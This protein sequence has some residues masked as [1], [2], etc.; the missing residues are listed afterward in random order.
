VT[1]NAR[2]VL[3]TVAQPAMENTPLDIDLRTF[4]T[5]DLTAANL[6]S[7]DPQRVRNGTATMLPNG[8]TARFTPAPNFNGTASFRITARDRSLGPRMLFLYDFE[9]PDVATDAR[10]T[11]QSNFNRTGTLEI[12]GVGGEYNYNANVPPATIPGSQSLGL[13][14]NTT[15]GA[16]LRRTLA[17][18]DQNYNDADW[19]FSAWVKRSTRDT[20]DYIF[21]LGNGD[22]GGGNAELQLFFPATS[23]ILRLQKYSTSAL[24]NEI[25]GP[26]PPHRRVAPRHRGL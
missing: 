2:P 15:G 8:Y 24:T 10:S 26:K 1:V 20:D 5:D 7:F 25:V 11:D 14:E 12:A 4:V 13:S 18:T 19:S 23:D 17:A 6:I 22:G 16:R 21:Y 3:A 9:P